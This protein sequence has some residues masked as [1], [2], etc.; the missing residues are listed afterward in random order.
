MDEGG[1]VAYA[2][3]GGCYGGSGDGGGDDDEG[4]IGACE[5]PG[6]PRAPWWTGGYGGAAGERMW[7]GGRP[8][9]AMRC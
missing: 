7:C 9:V 3:G 6:F 8:I 5:G 4:G 2:D 1:G